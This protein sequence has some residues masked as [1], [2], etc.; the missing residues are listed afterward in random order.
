[1][2]QW[3]LARFS[4]RA[5]ILAYHRVA[6]LPSDP[7]LLAV[8]PEKFERH[9]QIIRQHFTILSLDQ[10]CKGLEGGEIPARAV[11]VTFDDGYADNLYSAKPL[12]ER[13]EVPATIF[14]TTGYIGKEREFWWDEL[15]GLLLHPGTLPR[16]LRLR[17]R[18]KIFEWDLGEAA[19]YPEETWEK[20]RHWNLLQKSIPGCRQHTYKRLHRLLRPLAGSERDQI[21]AELWDWRGEQ[22]NGRQTNRILSKDELTRLAAGGL[23]SIGSHTVNHPLLSSVVRAEGIKEILE[24][25]ATLEQILEHPVTGFSYPFGSWTTYTKQTV[26][27]IRDSGYEWACAA[28]PGAVAKKTNRW[29]LP[30]FLVRNWDGEEFRERLDRWL[31]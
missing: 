21:L 2:A 25:K 28:F 23:V 6:E 17:I 15:Q 12:L 1:M 8:T 22:P 16:E 14:V 24:S 27:I 5:A 30:R 13:Y 29:Q 26:D 7:Q 18:G 31:S 3:A 19:Q 20:H 10:L 11:A 9:L 4:P